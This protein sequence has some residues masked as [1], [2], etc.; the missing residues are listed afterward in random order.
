VS[1]RYRHGYA[2]ALPHGLP[3][4]SRIPPQEF[5]AAS[6]AAAGAHRARPRSTRFEPVRRLKD[7]NAGSSRT[8]FRHARRARTIW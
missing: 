2:A 7:V 6:L 4:S 3:G 1:Q 8:P 5:P